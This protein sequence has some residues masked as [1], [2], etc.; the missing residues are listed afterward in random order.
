MA[1]LADP[2]DGDCIGNR[3][4]NFA[5]EHLDF[6][7]RWLTKAARL[8]GRSLHLAVALLRIASAQNAHQVTLSNLAS[9]QFG[10]DRNAK[11]RALGWLEEAGLVRVERKRGR[12]PMVTLLSHG[13]CL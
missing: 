6:S 8:P 10:L 1:D 3:P 11:Y 7:Q 13:N 12:S 9:Q 4:N 2:I 5:L